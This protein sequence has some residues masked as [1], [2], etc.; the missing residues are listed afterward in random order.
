M[1]TAIYNALNGIKGNKIIALTYAKAVKT[2][3]SCPING[4]I[5]KVTNMV[6]Q[7]GYS[8][9]NAVKNRINKAGGDPE[10]FQAETL[11]WGNWI[12]PNKFIEHNGAIY[13]RF[14]TMKNGKSE[15]TYY[16]NGETASAAE[17]EIIKQFLPK[18]S[19]S[20]KQSAAGLTDNQ[21][22]PFNI[23]I[24]NILQIKCK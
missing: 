1:N 21:V 8:Y 7:F 13:A 18:R 9:E 20:V 15:S 22:T 24:D 16:I 23:N 2:L 10:N 19:T 17:T 6:C 4:E 12:V 14:Y 3:K 5:T 11:P